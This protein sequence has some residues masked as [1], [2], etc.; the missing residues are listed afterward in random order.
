MYATFHN[1]AVA[2]ITGTIVRR[3]RHKVSA[4][5]GPARSQ[6]NRTTFPPS[7]DLTT[8]APTTTTPYVSADQR[9]TGTDRPHQAAPATAAVSRTKA[10]AVKGNQP[11][12]GNSTMS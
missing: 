10:P 4:A 6:P 3:C 11:P 1:N 9:T 5:T 7:G 2:A 12:S 8:N